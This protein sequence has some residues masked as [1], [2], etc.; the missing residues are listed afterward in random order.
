MRQIYKLSEKVAEFGEDQHIIIS[1]ALLSANL[2]SFLLKVNKIVFE[3]IQ[4]T[5]YDDIEPIEESTIQINVG[6]TFFSW[7][8]VEAH[9]NQYAKYSQIY[10][11]CSHTKIVDLYV[12][13]IFM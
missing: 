6:N 7:E 11:C 8:V 1:E 5:E 9:L 13:I 4:N 2:F 10:L 3:M 12:H